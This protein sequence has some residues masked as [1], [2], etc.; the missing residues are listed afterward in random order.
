MPTTV[1]A[2]RLARLV[3]GCAGVAVMLPAVALP[4]AA[5][6]RQPPAAKQPPAFEH[7]STFDVTTNGTAVAEIVTSTKDGRTLLYSDAETGRIGFVDVRDP[8]APRPAGTIELGGEPTSVAVAGKYALAA[9]DTSESYTDPSGFV[10]VIDVRNRRVV[11]TMDLGGQPDSVAIAP[12]GKYAAIAIENERDEDLDDGLLPQFPGGELVLVGLRGKPSRWSTRTVDL[13]GLADVAPEDPEPEYVDINRRDQAVVSL[14]ENN[15]LVVVDLSSGEVVNDFSAGSV[16]LDNVDATEE[17]LGPQGNGLVELTETI[18]RRRE[19]DTVTWVDDDT[20][21]TANEGDYEDGDGEEGGSRG[22]TL[23]NVDGTVE[24][25]SGPAFEHDSIRVG[26]YNETRSANKGGEPEAVAAARFGKHDLLFVGSERANVVG[27]YDVTEGDPEPMQ[28]L[29]TG[30]GPESILPLPRRGLLAVSAETSEEGISSMIT[31]YR[32]DRP[33]H[34]RHGG[35]PAHHGPSPLQLQS[36]DDDRGV[37]VP[38][39]A[40]SGLAGDPADASKLYAV[41][42]SFLASGYIYPIDLA[43][44]DPVITDRIEVSGTAM[45]LDMEGIAVGPDGRFWVASEGRDGGRPNALL[46]VDTDGTVL[47][48]I[49]LPPSLTGPQTDS[50]F[51]GIAVTG[52]PGSEVVYAPIQRPWEDD[53]DGTVRIARYEVATGEW[54]FVSY[55]LDDVESPNGGWVG[56]SELTLLPD[57]TFAVLERDNQLGGDARIKRLYGVDLESAEFRPADETP[58][59]VDKTL[60]RDTLPD[61]E[62]AS[63]WTPDKLEGVAVSGEGHVYIVTDNDGLDGNLGETVFLDLGPWTRALEG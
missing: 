48:E 57:G 23:F 25:E 11:R 16:T 15:H 58:I 18:T 36:T 22:Y 14:Q 54:A 44:G 1:R 21:A 63:I 26:H 17:E 53:A 7:V 24:Y 43:S 40:L 6:G 3:A 12:R 61:L 20:F 19:P 2:Q 33:G 49:E 27:V 50:G 56:L 8:A 38:W 37:P 34:G 60:L 47:L 45:S 13:T 9:V 46:Q 31:L 30:I 41:S 51:E 42:D 62:A 5:H 52:E 28:M 59:V 32:V 55:A 39:V 29:P 10:A 35:R 4:A